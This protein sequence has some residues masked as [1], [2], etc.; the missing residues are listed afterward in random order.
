MSVTQRVSAFSSMRHIVICGLPN[1][2]LRFSKKK[3]LNAKLVFW[4]SLQLLSKTFSIL[5]I[6]ERDMINIR[7]SSCKVPFILARFWWHLNFLGR[8]SENPQIS[9]FTKMR[10]VGA[11]LFHGDGRTDRQT[12]RPTDRQT[13]RSLIVALRNFAN[14]PTNE[15]TSHRGRNSRVSNIPNLSTEADFRMNE[16]FPFTYSYSQIFPFSRHI[17]LDDGDT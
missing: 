4:F 6:N 5:K 9:N 14:A 12:Y 17:Y 16:K 13:W 1:L 7:L 11:E 10:V 2:T 8:F 15:S 3:L